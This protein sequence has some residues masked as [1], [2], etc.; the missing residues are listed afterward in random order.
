M[1][2]C[3]RSEQLSHRNI[4]LSTREVLYPVIVNSWKFNQHSNLAG[5]DAMF[6][7]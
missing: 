1:I 6:I 7:L 2:F 3:G 5:I 4:V